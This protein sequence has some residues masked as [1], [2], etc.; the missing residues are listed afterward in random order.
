[1][2]KKIGVIGAG[3][4][5]MTAAIAAAR[6]GARV[7][8]FE[9]NDRVG[10]KILMTGNGRCNLG[11][12]ALDASMYHSDRMAFVE[13]RLREFGTEETLS[14]F[15][16]LGLMTKDK[17]GYLYP[18]CEQASAV[19]DVLRS[20]IK[21]LSV[22]LITD[23]KIT[24]LE[25]A[26][27]GGKLSLFREGEKGPADR[28]VFDRVII[29]CGGMAAPSTG[30]DGNGYQL[31]GKIGHRIDSP[32][33]AL[34]QLRCGER[35]LQS[36]AGV[37]TDAYVAIRKNG[38]EMI[39]ERG[40]L[41]LTDYGISGIPVFQ[42]SRTAARLLEEYEG[43]KGLEVHID[44]LP[45]YSGEEYRIFCRDRRKRLCDR[46]V[47]SFFTGML[48]K[49]LMRLFIRMAGLKGEE[50]FK[51]ADREKID[52]VF[53]LCRDLRVTV[54]GTNSFANAQVTAGGIPLGE[55]TEKFE[56]RKLPGVYFAGEI[57][58]VDGKCGGYNLQW[59]WCSGY[60]AGT[61]AA[62]D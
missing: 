35:F 47:E 27:A 3:A 29:A 20:E 49:K 2:A 7:T 9:R 39:G 22:R 42:I 55:I 25:K 12:R 23:C 46:N 61:A 18:A 5:G 37:R 53:S 28:E 36:V 51:T 6:A 1:M 50:A 30:S 60:I 10:K 45:D 26:D 34:V 16:G 38:R 19:L 59:A 43:N 41:Q 24:G 32:V 17:N 54:T 62:Q 13:E 15:D 56:S 4:A 48:N 11:N 14:F 44:F 8:L 40:E 58:D 21:G 33:P 31:A 52:R 57:L